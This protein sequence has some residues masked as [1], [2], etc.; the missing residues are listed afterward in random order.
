MNNAHENYEKVVYEQRRGRARGREMQRLGFNAICFSYKNLCEEPS[1]AHP[2]TTVTRLLVRGYYCSL[3]RG[4]GET[5]RNIIGLRLTEGSG[6]CN[7]RQAK[8]KWDEEKKD[9]SKAHLT[10]WETGKLEHL[11]SIVPIALLYD[12]NST[13]LSWGASLVG[14]KGGRGGGGEGETTALNTT[15][16]LFMR[17]IRFY[18]LRDSSWFHSICIVSKFCA[19]ILVVL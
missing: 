1:L 11:C 16:Q 15:K 8:Q 12:R 18:S 4:R 6:C 2:S 13:R 17:P 5:S 9:L 7:T 3:N 14:E 19:Y 10:R